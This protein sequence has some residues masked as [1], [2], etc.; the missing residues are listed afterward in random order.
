MSF[1]TEEE[2]LE[3][4][5]ALKEE[6]HD[7]KREQNTCSEIVKMLVI[8]ARKLTAANPDNLAVLLEANT[9]A[10]QI[11]RTNAKAAGVRVKS[12]DGKESALW[13]SIQRIRYAAV[14]EEDRQEQNSYMEKINDLYSPV[15]TSDTSGGQPL[16]I[17][18]EEG[19]SLGIYIEDDES[20][21]GFG[22]TLSAQEEEELRTLLNDRH[23]RA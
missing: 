2:I 6:R 14:E 15:W 8:D 9:T 1:A 22:L 11:A 17:A 5:D 23:A 21:N 12:L 3:Q 13:E 10:Q 18:T 16:L 19:N 7:A 20:D 4:I